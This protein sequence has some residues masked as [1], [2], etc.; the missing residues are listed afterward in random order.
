MENLREKILGCWLGKAVGGTLGQPYEGC[1]GPLNLSFYNPV[2]DDMIPNDDLDLQVLWACV[3]D[4]MET[5]RVDRDIFA[6]AW[7]N[8]VEFPWDEYGVAIK[9]LRNGIKA[10]FSGSYDNWFSNGLGAAIRSEIWACLAPGKPELAA[11]YAYE[12]ACV[13]HDG[14]GIWAEVFLA[15]LESLA[16]VENDIK[17]IIAKALN[18]IPNDSLLKSAVNDTLKWCEE[19]E[20]WMEIRGKILGKHGHENFTD[21]VMNLSFAILGLIKGKGDFDETLCITV[22]CGRDADCTTAS[23]GSI[24]GIMNPDSISKKWLEPIGR[25]LVINKEITGINPPESID[26]FTDMILRLKDKLDGKYPPKSTN[27]FNSDERQIKVKTWFIN[28]FPQD[29]SLHL[30]DAPEMPKE[31]IT[32]TLPG[33]K[34]SIDADIF[35]ADKILLMKYKIKLQKK[36]EVKVMFNTHDNCRVWIDGKYAFGREGGRMA[37]SFH[38]VPVN[39]Q[40]AL[41]LDAGEHEITAGIAPSSGKEKIE[42]VIGVG[43]A[44][45]NQ[46]LNDIFI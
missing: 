35:E 12:D 42:W 30:N 19:M 41:E 21:V 27:S 39:Q 10:P 17:K 7:L 34:A 38:R 16:F 33:K 44:K 23:V 13:D 22:N 1:D 25:K 26:G 40:T 4:E 43:D 2:P 11:A 6:E 3:M 24:L 18:Y 28:W 5:P 37:P 31:T 9:N 46:W 36:Q 32:L 45:T 20:D 29:N 8:K 14:D 15:A